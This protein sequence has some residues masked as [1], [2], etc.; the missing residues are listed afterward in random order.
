MKAFRWLRVDSLMGTKKELGQLAMPL[1]WK[2]NYKRHHHSFLFSHHCNY[3]SRVHRILP[4]CD[5]LSLKYTKI[6]FFLWDSSK[7][8]K[9]FHQFLIPNF[10]EFWG[11][12]LSLSVSSGFK[13]ISCWWLKNWSWPWSRQ[14]AGEGPSLPRSAT[15]E[16]DGSLNEKL[17]SSS[18]PYWF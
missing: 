6:A 3:T 13:I 1:R 8:F 14:V 2:Y 15:Q 7:C 10:L 12:H 17:L 11:N 18:S 16:T 4:T 9:D 5:Q